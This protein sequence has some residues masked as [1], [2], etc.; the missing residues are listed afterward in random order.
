MSC[1]PFVSK[2]YE[3]VS[4]E[5]TQ[6]IVYWSSSGESF[7]IFN[8]E[9][10]QSQILPMYFKHGNIGSFI[11]Q[12]NSYGFRKVCPTQLEFAH[13]NFNALNPCQLINIKRKNKSNKIQNNQC[14]TNDITTSLAKLEEAE[15]L[16][17]RVCNDLRETRSGIS[18]IC[19]KIA[20]TSPS[21]YTGSPEHYVHSL[22]INPSII[23]PS[24][25]PKQRMVTSVPQKTLTFSSYIPPTQNKSEL[26]LEETNLL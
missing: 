19:Y 26:K 2:T 10:F 25:M 6:N 15:H 22:V 17:E 8:P 1:A 18:A 13:P 14:E 20:N 5:R 21:P 23:Y 4:D 7:V 24:V 11:R 9:D 16:L 12:L 3:I